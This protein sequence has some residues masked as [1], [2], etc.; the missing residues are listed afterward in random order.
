MSLIKTSKEQEAI[1]A[2]CQILASLLN[3]L[4]P[5]VQ[6]G[7]HLLTLEE[8]AADFI[9]KAGA[10][11]AFKGY[12][13]YK[14]I[15]CTSINEEVVHC[16]P[17]ARQLQSGDILSIDAGVIYK[18]MYSDCA[19]TLP[20]GEIADEAKKL[21]QVTRDSLYLEAVNVIKPGNTLGDIGHAVQSYVEAAGYSVVRSLVGHGVG[22]KLHEDPAIPN[23]GKPHTGLTLKAGMV[24]AVE[25]M[26]NVGTAE[27]IFQPD[28]WR[29]VTADG[30]LSAHFEHT[31]LVTATG[32]EVLTAL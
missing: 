22:S 12:K 18:G 17:T 10:K 32:C 5:L 28:G 8:Y 31:I 16:P 19:I 15:L 2:S 7:V 3:Y 21:I 9:K 20:V 27:V 25:P 24:I 13:G 1:R 14:N 4:I 11:P 29:V 23:Y 30:K 6:P 26:V